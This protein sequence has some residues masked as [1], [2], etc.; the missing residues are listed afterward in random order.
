MN[1]LHSPGGIVECESL[2]VT[3]DALEVIGPVLGKGRTCGEDG[4]AMIMAG[5]TLGKA[6]RRDRRGGTMA[7]GGLGSQ[8]PS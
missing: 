2:D 7:S 3:L 5:G 1:D 4:G 6:D 8:S